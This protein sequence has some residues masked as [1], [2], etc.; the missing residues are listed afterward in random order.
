M[1]PEQL[2]SMTLAEFESVA[3]RFSSAL[4]VLNEAR[5]LMGG[6]APEAAPVAAVATRHAPVPVVQWSPAELAERERLRQAR[7]A[8]M[9]ADI[10]AAEATS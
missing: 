5:A 7:I 3:A 6:A 9:P 1:T 8:A 2:S 4:K 10:Q